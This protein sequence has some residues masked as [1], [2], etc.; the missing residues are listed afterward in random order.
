LRGHMGNASSY[1]NKSLDR[2]GS[3]LRG[4]Y[5]FRWLAVEDP[6]RRML[7]QSMATAQLCPRHVGDRSPPLD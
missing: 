2:M 6:R 5:K 1:V 4:T 7:L 3:R